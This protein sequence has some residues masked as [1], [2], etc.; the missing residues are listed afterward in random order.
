MKEIV[1]VGIGGAV[2]AICRFLLSRTIQSIFGVPFPYGTLVVN[3]LGSFFV[4]FLSEVLIDRFVD[5]NIELRAFFLI[6]L[7]GAFTTFSSFSYEVV[8]FWKNGWGIGLI[9]YF[10]LSIILCIGGA[11]GGLF[12]GRKL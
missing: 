12:I 4:T 1:L 11:V 7:L 3:V 9:V 5:W 10:L 8:D 6:G 2:G